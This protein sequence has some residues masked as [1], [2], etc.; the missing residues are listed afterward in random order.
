M[1]GK[2]FWYIRVVAI[3]CTI[4]VLTNFAYLVPL[5]PKSWLARYI[6][7]TVLYRIFYILVGEKNQFKLNVLHV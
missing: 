6:I 3:F 5:V 1:M 2:G 7:Y 4:C